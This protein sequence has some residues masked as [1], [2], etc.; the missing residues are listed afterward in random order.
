MEKGFNSDVSWLG[1]DYHVQTEDWGASN[2]YLV[3]RVFRNGAVV[4]SI[5]TAY[6]EVL[7]D[8]PTV[9]SQAIR[10]AMKIQHQQILDLLLSGK[11]L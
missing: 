9:G 5:K 11:L 4:K 1:S 7:P 6:T 3:S 8:S 2:P 10:L